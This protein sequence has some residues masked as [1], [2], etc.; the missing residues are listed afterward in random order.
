M[1]ATRVWRRS[2]VE[3]RPQVAGVWVALGGFRGP[4]PQSVSFVVYTLAVGRG[5][6]GGRGPRGHMQ[7]LVFLELVLVGA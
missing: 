5:W 4:F 1:A 3:Q 7:A 2:V 6:G